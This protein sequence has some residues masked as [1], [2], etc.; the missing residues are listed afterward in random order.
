MSNECPM[1]WPPQ[2]LRALSSKRQGFSASSKRTKRFEFLKEPFESQ[3]RVRE[4]WPEQ[5]F[6]GLVWK[7]LLSRF[8]LVV[9]VRYVNIV[10]KGRREQ[11]EYSTTNP[12]TVDVGRT[13]RPRDVYRRRCYVSCLLTRIRK[14]TYT[15]ENFKYFH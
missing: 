3:G 9:I 11:R 13:L 12:F 14:M 1:Q 2:T 10:L 6:V 15:E 8:L 7:P 4:D 5:S